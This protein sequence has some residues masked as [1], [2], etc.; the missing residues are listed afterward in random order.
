VIKANVDVK[1]KIEIW[2]EGRLEGDVRACALDIEE[3]ATFLGRSEMSPDGAPIGSLTE[4]AASLLEPE[5]V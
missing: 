3:G 1:G 2:K 5:T 4:A